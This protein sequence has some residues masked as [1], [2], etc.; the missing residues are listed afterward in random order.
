MSL[1]LDSDVSMLKCISKSSRFDSP[2][3]R[4]IAS[5]FD[6]LLAIPSYGSGA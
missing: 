5:G 6:K 4:S 3:Y 2:F 1:L